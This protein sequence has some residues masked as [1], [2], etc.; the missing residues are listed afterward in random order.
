MSEN[1]PCNGSVDIE[2]SDIKALLSLLDVRWTPGIDSSGEGVWRIIGH[3]YSFI[4]SRD[5]ED[6]DHRPEYLFLCDGVRKRKIGQNDGALEISLSIDLVRLILIEL[7]FASE[8][9]RR[10]PVVLI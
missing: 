6:D 1:D 9:Y 5:L 8:S 10:S 3:L 7:L 2:V 4:N